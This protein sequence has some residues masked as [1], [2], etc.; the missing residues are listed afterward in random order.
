MT[1]LP[2]P[3]VRGLRFHLPEKVAALRP[4]RTVAL[5]AVGALSLAGSVY[6]SV[7]QV[8]AQAEHTAVVAEME[9]ALGALTTSIETVTS[10][11]ALNQVQVAEY[12]SL[13]LEQDAA[14][15]STDGFI[16]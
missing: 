8:Q 14:L 6:I 7:T 4:S 10:Q 3:R 2:L 11:V 1:T 9:S 15:A 13:V 16:Q 12:R 5:A